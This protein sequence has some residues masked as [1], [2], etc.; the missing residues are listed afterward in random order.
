MKSRLRTGAAHWLR[1]LSVVASLALSLA[2]QPACAAPAVAK[3]DPA[4]L[5]AEAFEAAQ[6]AVRSDAAEALAKLSVRFAKGADAIAG[7]TTQRDALTAHRDAVE[8]RLEQL[9]GST[10]ANADRDRA[11]A[12]ADYDQTQA[13]LDALDKT[14]EA[15]FPAYAELTNPKAASLAQ[16]Q[17][18][19]KPNEGLI[20]ILVNPEATYV[21]GLTHDQSVWARAD[22]LG[23]K[24]LG[25]AVTRLRQQLHLAS[26]AAA[27]PQGQGGAGAERYDIALAY[28]LYDRLIRPVEGVFK[29]KTTLISV[30]T[31]PLSALPLAALPT[32]P[33]GA[34]GDSDEGLRGLHWL[35]DRYALATLP[36]VSS[37]KTLRCDLVAAADRAPGCPPSNAASRVSAAQ[38]R[39]SLVGFGAPALDP[40]PT[41]LKPRTERATFPPP[42]CSTEPTPIG[43]S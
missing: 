20:F 5:R 19:L 32:D 29:G 43:T 40:R 14:I 28:S 38:D 31:G 39:L 15:S 27:M 16:T 10:A 24:P 9:Y 34:A 6:W 11:L 13:S 4:A 26:L 25:D 36:A 1:G 7:L 18:L 41:G 22:D 33:P 2:V 8:R 17:A 23:E 21:W 37:L 12:R 42:R 30:T 35:I 3:P